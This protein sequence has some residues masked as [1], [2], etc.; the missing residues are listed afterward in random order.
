[1]T[2]LLMPLMKQ[3]EI[4]L[5][6]NNVTGNQRLFIVSSVLHSILNVKK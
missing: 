6:G 3:E 1:M 2:F 5:Q 4:H